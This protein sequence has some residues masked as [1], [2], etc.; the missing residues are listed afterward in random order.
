MVKPSTAHEHFLR[1]PRFLGGGAAPSLL[2]R[3]DQEFVPALL[4][5]VRSDEGR[6]RARATVA[7][8]REAGVGLRLWQPVHRIFHLAV[9]EALCDELGS[10]RVDPKRI[11]SAGLVVRRVAQRRDAKGRWLP[12]DLAL[13]PRAHAVEG[14]MRD[15][16]LVHG[17]RRLAG[18]EPTLDPDPARR[19]PALR[20]GHPAVTARL[21]QADP[22]WARW[23]ET[24]SPLFVAP[25][26]ACAQAG[27]TLL[28]GVVPVTSAEIAEHPGEAPKAD[29]AGI[30]AMVPE[31]LLPVA[32]PTTEAADE[33]LV[34][35]T[36][37]G[38]EWVLPEELK[39][40]REVSDVLG[41]RIA[42]L[43]LLRGIGAFEGTAEAEA[44]LAWLDEIPVFRTGVNGSVGRLG[45]VLRRAAAV[46]ERDD[47][48]GPGWEARWRCPFG[49]WQAELRRR[50]AP[51]LNRR[52]D[53]M[54]GA[55]GRFDR[56]G[57]YYQVRAF[58]RLRRCDGCPPELVW[59][60]PSEPFTIVPWFEASGVP[61]V[62]VALPEA[63]LAAMSKLKPNV[64]F[65]VPAS[66]QD[67]LA[68]LRI[69]KPLEVEKGNLKLGLDWICGFSIPLITLCA[70][71]VL[72]I[73]LNL[74][75]II[76][77]WLPFIR[78]CIPIPRVTESPRL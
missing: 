51:L 46:F 34:T 72:F 73:F 61:P 65:Q 18:D 1:G 78:I 7:G 48:A 31:F 71:I 66:L 42:D 2:K 17:W 29:A 40:N 62:R 68:G 67:A 30:A 27:A 77:W 75:N 23:E 10:P 32:R 52:V 45:E 14:W 16:D 22:E 36:G 41:A 64:A 60:E 26:D 11:E 9:V 38:I 74:L 44:L 24:V 25:P 8:D 69:R 4:A 28:Y 56:T 54:T 35:R 59:T 5:E 50:I 15:G 12:P 49:A 6:T 21:R 55:V 43:A 70:F 37:A 3:S 63:T 76:F 57:G 19:R 20:D 47:A 13:P 33:E 53:E 58:A 39:P